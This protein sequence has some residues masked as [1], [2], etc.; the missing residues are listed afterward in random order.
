MLNQLAYIY[1]GQGDTAKA[2]ETL[3]KAVVAVPGE[4]NLFDS[5]GELYAKS[6][7]FDEA[8]ENYK[9]AIALKPDFGCDE[10][11]AYL[12]AV[13]GNYADALAWIDQF[14]LMAPNNESKGRGYWWK[15]IFDH[16]AGRREQ[17]G[18]EMDRVRTLTESLGNQYGT[19]MAAVRPGLS[20]LRPGRIR[21]GPRETWRRRTGWPRRWRPRRRSCRPVV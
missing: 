19:A 15:A 8:I 6:G 11:I 17:A 5:L 12:R 16:L 3:E 18:K 7:R 2:I 1:E 20:P 21:R 13:Q 14:I 9:K 4:P 10:I